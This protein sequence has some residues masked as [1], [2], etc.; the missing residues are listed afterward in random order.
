MQESCQRDKETSNG[1]YG[2]QI[3]YILINWFIDDGYT[4]VAKAF[5]SSSSSF[6]KRTESY[7]SIRLP[8][9][10]PFESRKPISYLVHFF[11]ANYMCI[12]CWQFQRGLRFCMYACTMR[13]K[14]PSLF[15]I[16]FSQSLSC[17]S[18]EFD[19]IKIKNSHRFLFGSTVLLP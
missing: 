1:W 12:K 13:N 9:S 7:L 11:S 6:S 19:P 2:I 17:E 14:S 15:S 3:L 16:R 8:F 5:S 10:N 18:I 4:F